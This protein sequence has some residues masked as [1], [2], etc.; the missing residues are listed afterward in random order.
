MSTQG[1]REFDVADKA[2]EQATRFGFPDPKAAVAAMAKAHVPTPF[3]RDH[4]RCGV[5]LMKVVNR[6][7]VQITLG[8]R[9]W[10]KSSMLPPRG[11]W[12]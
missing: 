2:I 4:I 12:Q 3:G 8:P 10:I 7:V 6:V 9:E 1:F 11:D 5:F